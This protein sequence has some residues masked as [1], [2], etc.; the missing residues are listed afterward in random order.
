MSEVAGG[1]NKETADNEA[2]QARNRT[3]D[4]I[5]RS[6]AISSLNDGIEIATH[7]LSTRLI[8]W[9]GNGFQTE[10]V[11][12]LTLRPGEASEMYRYDMAEEALLSLKGKGEVFLRGRWVEVEAGDIAF[13]PERV[14]HAVRNPKENGRDLVLVSAIS[15]PPFDLYEPDGYYDKQHGMMNFEAIEDAQKT[16]KL[17][18]LSTDNE[19][20]PNESHPELRAWNL[21]AEDVRRAGALFNFYKGASAN[22]LNVPM[23]FVLWPGYGVRATGLHTAH[24][25]PGPGGDIHTHPVTDELLILWS[26]KSRAY[27]GDR[28]HELDTYGCV[29]APCG[30]HHGASDSEESCLWGG[31]AAP[32]QLDLYLKT[33]YYEDGKFSQPPFTNLA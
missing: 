10:S 19:M 18:T 23:V 28:W 33:E 3:H 13:F 21:D 26:G 6:G 11:H 14:P 2:Y 31:F 25:A 5:R 20:H 27:C 29:M 32:P 8:A 15:P 4:E 16:A 1:Q 7:G 17:G 24:S 9:P 12:V 22:V 30:V